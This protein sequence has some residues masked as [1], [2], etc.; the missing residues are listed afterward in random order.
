MTREN[1]RQRE[2]VWLWLGGGCALLLSFFAL[3]LWVAYGPQA[4]IN[5]LTAI[6]TCL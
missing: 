4:F 3:A 2:N 1:V 5:G 6:W